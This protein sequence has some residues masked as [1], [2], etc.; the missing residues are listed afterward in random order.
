[1]VGFCGDGANDC[2]ALKAADVGVSLSQAEASIAAPFTSK[3]QN[4]SC[5]PAL[6]K[7][8]RASLVT[9]FCCFKYMTLY[10]MIQFTTLIF[11]YS[12]GSTLSDGQFIYV[13]LLLIVPLGILMSR[14]APSKAL[15]ARQPTAKLISPD[16]LTAILGHIAIQAL[17]QVFVYF[18]YAAPLAVNW[19]VPFTGEDPNTYHPSTSVMF[20]FSA[21]L[22][23]GTALIF[24]AGR[25]FRER[26]YWPFVMYAMV[27]LLATLSILA[28]RMQRL[29]DWLDLTFVPTSTRLGIA[30]AGGVYFAIAF[31]F[32]QL[33]VSPLAAFIGSK[34]NFETR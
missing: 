7:E 5:V 11:L 14:Y 17:V 32:D 20:L 3:N 31:V 4:I 30:V 2:G 25:P 34:F 26:V 9:S 16:I 33:M 13:D 29:E 28:F 23:I 8:G 22:Y 24:S 12:Y 19:D 21:F 15:V 1:V 10:S 27:G 6:L 18:V